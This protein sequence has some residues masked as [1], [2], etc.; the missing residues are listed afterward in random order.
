[1]YLAGTSWI[2]SVFGLLANL[3]MARILGPEN[4]GFYAIVF[5]IHSLIGMVGAFSIALAVVQS[6]DESDALYDTGFAWIRRA[7]SGRGLNNRTCGDAST[8]GK[9]TP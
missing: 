5:S 9:G 8:V 4:L 7:K 1:M 6:S 2:T 3:A